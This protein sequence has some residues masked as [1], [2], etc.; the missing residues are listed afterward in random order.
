ML[1][2]TPEPFICSAAELQLPDGWIFLEKWIF[3]GSI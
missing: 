1:Q 3:S 2:G